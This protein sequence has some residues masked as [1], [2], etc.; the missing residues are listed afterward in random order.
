MKTA[1]IFIFILFFLKGIFLRGY[2]DELFDM[3]LALSKQFPP[4]KTWIDLQVDPSFSLDATAKDSFIAR[5]SCLKIKNDRIFILD[6]MRHKLLVFDIKGKFIKSLGQSGRGPG[7][8][9]YPYW[10]ELYKNKIYIKND[11]GIDIIGDDLKYISRVRPFLG[12]G[13]FVIVDDWIYCAPP[14]I[15]KKDYPLLLKLNMAGSIKT[16]VYSPDLQDPLFQ[17]SK[18]GDLLILD[19]Q[20]VFVCTHWNRLYFYDPKAGTLKKIKVNYDLL[21]KVEKWNQRNTNPYQRKNLWFSNMTASAKVFNRK[22]YLLLKVPRLE[23]LG[24]DTQG[25]VIEHYFNNKDFS[26]M[27]WVDFVVQ[28]KVEKAEQGAQRNSPIFFVMGI[29]GAE[30]GEEKYLEMN[31]FRLIPAKKPITIDK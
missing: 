15:Y 24:I 3:K 30:K 12:F 13:K 16:A 2:S 17:V 4:D 27:I 19:D 21:D 26:S 22:V 6:N 10:M 7:D 11:N 23:I 29:S 14:E 9:V 20:L 8:I 28:E 1:F 31:V 18:E 25:N 5:G